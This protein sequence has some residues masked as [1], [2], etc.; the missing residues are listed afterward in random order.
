MRRIRDVDAY[1]PAKEAAKSLRQIADRLE[2][3]GDG[4]FVKYSLNV[5]TV[6]AEEINESRS[7]KKSKRTA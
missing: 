5:S 1:V 2:A 6:T 7:A 4:F 3:F